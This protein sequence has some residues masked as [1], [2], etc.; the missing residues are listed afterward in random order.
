MGNDVRSFLIGLIVATA[1]AGV[2]GA[3]SIVEKTE[4]IDATVKDNTR[5]IEERD[6]RSE[7]AILRGDAAIMRF[8][9]TVEKV[10]AIEHRLARIE[11][12]FDSLARYLSGH[13]DIMKPPQ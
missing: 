12:D 6:A 11:V 4:R 2:A 13:V 3:F 5:R 10:N 1:A 9:G 8:E 7:A